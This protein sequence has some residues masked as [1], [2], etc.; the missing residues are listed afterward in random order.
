M[1]GH[2]D[3]PAAAAALAASNPGQ[4]RAD[5]YAAVAESLRER[6]PRSILVFGCGRDASLLKAMAPDGALVL[7]VEDDHRWAREC[8][9]PVLLTRYRSSVSAWD[10]TDPLLAAD[11]WPILS[12]MRWDWTL[13][14]GPR[15]DSPSAPGRLAPIAYASGHSD[16]VLVHDIHRDA[17]AGLCRRYLQGRES[18]RVHHLDIFTR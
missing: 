6:R 2:I 7:W 13:V 9:G 1:I 4:M 16:T 15:G 11:F 5:E 3:I 17:E 10:T 18:R 14:D 8:Q 12:H